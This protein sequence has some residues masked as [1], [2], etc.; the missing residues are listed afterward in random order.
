[1]ALAIKLALLGGC[2][3]I[4]SWMGINIAALRSAAA[5]PVEAFL[6]LGGSIR[7]EI[8]AAELA[9]QQP[10]VPVLI[11]QGSE[12]PCIWLIFQNLDVPLHQVWLEKCA[13]STFGNFF[14]SLPILQQW[15]VH[16]VKL[17][18]SATH[19]PRALWLAHILLGA[20]GIWVEP[21]I[22]VEQGVPGNRESWG[23]TG[24][25]VTRSLLW[26]VASYLYQPHCTDVKR[27]SAVNIAAA[28]RQGFDCEHQ[29]GLEWNEGDRSQ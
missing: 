9:K 16:K 2:L 25:D 17:V 13:E 7:R 27:L 3:L 18:T 14:F 4:L 22:A 28:Q 23:K 29:A 24:L 19:L 5:H 8:Y 20:H 26:A 6:V 11:S 10:H 15:Q 21:D 1:L 12:D